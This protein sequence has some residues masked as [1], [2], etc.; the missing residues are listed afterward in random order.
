MSPLLESCDAV[1]SFGPTPALLPLA[2]AS[3]PKEALLVPSLR[4]NLH[5]T[6]GFLLALASLHASG[7]RRDGQS[8][9]CWVRGA[10]ARAGLRGRPRPT[11]SGGQRHCH[12]EPI[13]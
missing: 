13:S 7:S 12:L 1:L 9:G 11:P 3:L 6:K 10:S 2:Q 5:E 8:R 4:P